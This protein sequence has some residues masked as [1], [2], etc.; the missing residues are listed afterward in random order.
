MEWINTYDTHHWKI[1]RS[2]FRNLA[3]VGFEPTTDEFRS[4]AL[5]DWPIKP[6]VELIRWGNFVQQLH[7][8]LLGQCSRFI[9]VFAFVRWHICVKLSVILV[10]TLV[11]AWIDTC[12]NNHW[13]IFRSSYRKWDWFGLETATTEFRSDAQT[14]RS[15]KTW[16]QLALTANIVRLLQYCLFVDW[17]RFI[18]V[19][20]LVRLQICFKLYLTVI[21]TLAVEKIGTYAIEH[22]V[23]FWNS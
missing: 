17:S 4:N 6:W 15:I 18:S 8:H 11:A 13:R 7:Y 14:D 16:L 2:S 5:T 22:W 23:I 21:M 20:L 12:G 19:F 3:R 10:I 1:F 9:S